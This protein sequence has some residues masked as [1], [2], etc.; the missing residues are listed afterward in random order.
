[1]KRLLAIALV[2]SAAALAQAPP[3]PGPEQQRFAYFVGTWTADLDIKPGPFGPGGK[4]TFAERN[5]WFPGGFFLITHSDGS[6]PGMGPVKGQSIVAYDPEK[7]QYTYYE[8]NSAGMQEHATGQLDGDTWHWLSELAVGGKI[9]KTRYTVKQL[10]ATAYSMKYE[11]SQDG[12]T[13]T[14]MMEG[15]AKKTS[16]AS[17]KPAANSKMKRPESKPK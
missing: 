12:A 14:T 13:W 1:M 10:S 15:S 5:E 3:K 6:L 7:K 4:T 2:L 17:S 8:I 9:I 16:P 11:S